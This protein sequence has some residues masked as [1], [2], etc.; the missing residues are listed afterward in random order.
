[1]GRKKHILYS[2]CLCLLLAPFAAGKAQARFE[3]ENISIGQGIS[4]SDITAMLQDNTGFMWLATNNGLNSYDG[5]TFRTF[6]ADSRDSLTLASSIIFSIVED[7]SRYLWVATKDAIDRYD[8]HTESFKHYRST[9]DSYGQNVSLER[10]NSLCVTSAGDLWGIMRGYLLRFDRE[11]DRFHAHSVLNSTTNSRLAIF[12]HLTEGFGGRILLATN[13]GVHSVDPHTMK[14]EV[15][16]N[17]ET[18]FG[19]RSSRVLTLFTDHADGLLYVGGDDGVFVVDARNRFMREVKC[20]GASIA[21]A[22]AIMRDSSGRLWIATRERGIYIEDNGNVVNCTYDKRNA[23]T[24][25]SNYVLSLYEDLSGAMWVGTSSGGVSKMSLHHRPFYAIRHV[26]GTSDSLS[27]EVAYAVYADSDSTIWAATKDGVLNRITL[28]TG[29]VKHYSMPIAGS[30]GDN[31]KIYDIEPKDNNK[32]WL[33]TSHG[34]CVF[35]KSSGHFDRSP[36]RGLDAGVRM[37]SM[38]YDDDGLLWVL[39]RNTGIYVIDNDRLL[40][41]YTASNMQLTDDFVRGITQDGNGDIWIGTRGG[42]VNRFRKE[43]DGYANTV[44]RH[45]DGD[46]AS[47]SIDNISAMFRDSRDRL[48]IGTWGGGLNLV[49]DRNR[50]R[51]KVYTEQEGLCDNVIFDIFEDRAGKL[52]ITT[53]N[54]LSCFDPQTEQFRNYTVADGLSSNEFLN[55]AG[56]CTPQ[57]MMV[58]GTIKGIVVFRPEEVMQT[59]AAPDKLALV[60]LLVNNREVHPGERVGRRVLLDRPVFAT[61][62][63][64]LS[65]REPNFG[66]EMSSFSYGTPGRTRFAYR[67]EGLDKEWNYLTDGNSVSYSNLRPGK[68]TFMFKA[69]T[70]D[71]LWSEVPGRLDITVTPPLWGSRLAYFFYGALV[72]AVAGAIILLVRKRQAKKTRRLHEKMQYEGEQALY[73]AKMDF[74][75]NIS[76]ELRTPLALIIGLIERVNSKL[77]A[78]NAVSNQMIV[79][80]RNADRLLGLV[81]DLLDLR[82]I[83]TGNRK[84]KPESKDI[85]A[86][87][88][89]IWSYFEVDAESKGVSLFFNPRIESYVITADF[90][91]TEKILYNMVSNA[92]KFTDTFVEMSIARDFRDGREYVLITVRDNGP[93]ISE[94]EHEKIFYRFYQSDKTAAQHTGSGVGLNLALEM[95]RL[96]GGD[97]TVS[98]AV[99][100]GSSFCLR[101]PADVMQGRRADEYEQPTEAEAEQH[102]AALPVVKGGKPL[103]LV[104]DDNSDMRYYLRETLAGEYRIV[105]ADS[106]KDALDMALNLKPDLIL[107]DVMM[108]DMDGIEVCRRLKETPETRNI[109]V[110]LATAKV[111]EDS[112][113]EGLKQGADAYIIKPFTGDHLRAQITNIFQGRDSMRTTISREIISTPQRVEVL[114]AQD[115]LLAKVAAL[116]EKNIADPDYDVGVLSAD[117]HISRVHLYRQ[118]KTIFGQSPS[119]FIRDFRLARAASLLEQDKLDVSE[120]T[121]MVGFSSPKYFTVCFKKK[122]G[123]TP[124][125]YVAQR[126]KNE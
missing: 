70:S 75:T 23:Q 35:D 126:N 114:S 124:Q 42:G 121:Y 98:S 5:Y 109:P 74:F 106:G 92:I 11:A 119:D 41:R 77:G 93:G 104:V 87:A 32:L 66:V 43:D 97:L 37:R 33:A 10:V 72:L 52:W 56:Y 103:I 15:L 25:G 88:K 12:N 73:Q 125:E 7:A 34:M 30:Y 111:S 81:N 24:I 86:F 89:A 117:L 60:R 102:I 76:H 18:N 8:S 6:K 29:A 39:S 84:L 47:L 57:G 20:N 101:L 27:D 85:V 62:H 110:I 122:Y 44:M 28:Q 91:K 36:V 13:R 118:L 108:P 55:G 50:M 3:F 95:A 48:W 19:N 31:V 26:P 83:E 59:F 96:Q 115:K 16:F 53:Y 79:M 46:T 64:I 80:R 107:C 116:L 49:T 123:V 17:P 113:I 82:K 65:H 112:R 120:V 9:T 2:L 78:N 68:Y 38:M 1:M 58:F 51:V 71:D 99:G 54:G 100:K 105:E 4:Q 21:K 69:A 61:D 45:I 63:V 14:S 22:S 94:G 90:E 40:R 67:L